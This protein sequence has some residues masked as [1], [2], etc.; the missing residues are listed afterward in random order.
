[1]QRLSSAHLLTWFIKVLCQEIYV[2]VNLTYILTSTVLHIEISLP[3]WWHLLNAWVSF[4]LCSKAS[5]IVCHASSVLIH[6][7]VLVFSIGVRELWNNLV[8]LRHLQCRWLV[9][10]FLYLGRDAFKTNSST[11][12][13]LLSKCFLSW[14]IH[15][16]PNA[17][18][19]TREDRLTLLLAHIRSGEWRICHFLFLIL[20]RHVAVTS[21]SHLTWAHWIPQD[22]LRVLVMVTLIE[23]RRVERIRLISSLWERLLFASLQITPS[24]L[25]MH[26]TLGREG[27]IKAHVIIIKDLGLVPRLLLRFLRK[28]IFLLEIDEALLLVPWRRK[29]LLWLFGV[30]II[31]DRLVLRGSLVYLH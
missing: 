6:P 28:L 14:L 5:F 16:F 30:L 27:I 12:P 19:N 31:Y 13:F 7:T 8:L 22:R 3:V 23:D 25:A 18:H 10:L 17:A 4:L 15:L 29:C 2:N 11:A 1:M 20:T 26:G 9:L 21:V 24:R